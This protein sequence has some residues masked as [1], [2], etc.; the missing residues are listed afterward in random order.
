MS[1]MFTYQG[2]TMK[3]WNCFVGCEF[4]CTYC[5]ARKLAL[6]RLKHAERYK[7]GFSPHVV[8]KELRRRFNPG[9]FRFVA[10]M[11]DI[12]FAPYAAVSSI[13]E[14]VVSQPAV[15][16]LFCTKNPAV[17][18]SWGLEFPDNLYLGATIETNFDHG[19]SKAPA[20]RD[21]YIAMKVLDHP[22]KFISLE[23]L[24]NFHL[25]TLVDWI[26]EIRP[27]IIEIGPDNYH[28]SLPEPCSGISGFKA[29]W[30]VRILLEMMREVCPTVVEK[31]GLARLK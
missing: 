28:N 13:I 16:F 30:K 21:R 5:S 7:T 14:N 24:M 4:N 23:P 31:P 17:Y 9:D 2:K 10:Y 25:R 29:P 27:E 1:R 8:E 6:T 26:K 11:G 18:S 19:L 3:T 20:P 22:R 12:S 15:K